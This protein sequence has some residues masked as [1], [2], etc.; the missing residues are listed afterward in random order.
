MFDLGEVDCI[1]GQAHA[2]V[3]KY[4]IERSHN[5][6]GQKFGNKLTVG[7]EK[8]GLVNGLGLTVLFRG[9]HG[10]YNPDT[11]RTEDDF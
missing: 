10:G 2:R 6:E 1:V 3:L 8:G 11:H 5:I 9:S 4:E 7:F